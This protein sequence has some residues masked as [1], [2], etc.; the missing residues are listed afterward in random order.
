MITTCVYIKVKPECI[1]EFIEACGK[2]HAESVKEPGNLRFDVAQEVENPG[3]F[4]LY[5]AYI[6]EAAASAHKNTPHYYSWRSTVENM[7]IKPR[8]GVKHNILF[9]K[10]I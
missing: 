4:L 1:N 5:E 9:P 10:A 6:D 2:N 3:K 7:M 8:Y